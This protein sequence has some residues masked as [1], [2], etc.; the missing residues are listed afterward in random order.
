MD[1]QPRED[2][3]S[4]IRCDRPCGRGD[5]RGYIVDVEYAVLTGRIAQIQ[6]EDPRGNKYATEGTAMDGATLVGGVG[7]FPV[8]TGTWSSRFTGSC[9]LRNQ[10]YVWIS[11]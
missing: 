5:G 2:Q 7:A 3:V 9:D 8:A 11:L 1:G 6:R 10:T 4:A